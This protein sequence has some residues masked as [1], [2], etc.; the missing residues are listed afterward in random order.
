M[1]KQNSFDIAII[2]DAMLGGKHIRTL[3]SHYGISLCGEVLEKCSATEIE[4]KYT[5]ALKIAERL[6]ILGCS[7]R[8]NLPYFSASEHLAKVDA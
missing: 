2:A 1:V 7:S 3:Q 8:D 5:K 4:R 6:A